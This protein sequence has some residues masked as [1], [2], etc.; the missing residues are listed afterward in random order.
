[1]ADPTTT[2]RP[3]VRRV[4]PLWL[5]GALALLAAACSSSPQDVAVVGDSITVLV[6][7]RLGRVD[8]RWDVEAT[9]GATAQQM[10]PA[11]QE[12]SPH[13]Q[14]VVN[15]GTNDALGGVALNTT[16]A[17][18]QAII[19]GFDD[20]DCVH[21][22]T[23]NTQMPPSGTDAGRAAAEINDWLRATADG[24]DRVRLIAWDAELSKSDD[25]LRPDGIHPNDRGRAR[26]V[27]LMAD[28]VSS[29]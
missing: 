4:L 22:V 18:L 13:E 14:A 28:S 29:C 23:I 2:L 3:L 26:L 8:H 5:L 24:S 16:T 12:S 25:L 6:E 11:A 1:M 17:N 21:L 19:D 10:R 7:D 9:I 15:L 20:V 27:D